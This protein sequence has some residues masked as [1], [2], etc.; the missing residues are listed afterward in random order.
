MESNNLFSQYKQSYS[1]YISKS[2]AEIDYYTKMCN[3]VKL[4]CICL[5]PK[6]KCIICYNIEFAK[7]S[8]NFLINCHSRRIFEN[9]QIISNPNNFDNQK[10]MKENIRKFLC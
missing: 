4:D 5:T 9:R 7:N 2:Q 1:E 6:S 10:L 8:L 3:D